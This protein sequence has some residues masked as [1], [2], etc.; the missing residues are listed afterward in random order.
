MAKGKIVMRASVRGARRKGYGLRAAGRRIQTDLL[1]EFAGNL[2]P[3]AT[4]ITRGFAPHASGR[5]ERGLKAR[6]RSYGG[7]ISVEVI[8]TARADDGF[9][10]LRVTRF[11]H[12]EAIIYPVRKKAI[13]FIPGGAPSGKRIVRAWVRGYHP[14]HDWVEGAYRAM[15]QV[16]DEAAKRLGR[17]IDRRLLD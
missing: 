15:T 17:K 8:S 7:R 13:A 12:K 14:T 4:K 16:L 1:D 11:G 2:A 5:L 6:V 10:Y 9:D 3:E